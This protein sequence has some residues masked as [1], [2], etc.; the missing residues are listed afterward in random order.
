MTVCLGHPSLDREADPYS[1]HLTQAR[2][3]SPIEALK[4]V[5]QLRLA[6]AYSGVS[7]F[8]DSESVGIGGETV[9]LLAPAQWQSPGTAAL[10]GTQW[11]LL[12]LLQLAA[13]PAPPTSA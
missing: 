12:S 8:S 9:T 1:T 4:D 2:F 6:D 5:R 11:S 3:V 10:L 7:D 13:W